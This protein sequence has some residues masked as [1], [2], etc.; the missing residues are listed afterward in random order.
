MKDGAAADYDICQSFSVISTFHCMSG[1][2]LQ[3]AIGLLVQHLLRPAA[4]N[5]VNSLIL[6]TS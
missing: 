4:L 6:F 5:M 2:V 3:Q 1:G